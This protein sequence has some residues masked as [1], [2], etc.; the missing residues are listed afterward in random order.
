ME[1]SIKE[2]LDCYGKFHG[3]R[4][5]NFACDYKIGDFGRYRSYVALVYFNN[6][7]RPFVY[8]S[9]TREIITNGELV[10]VSTLHELNTLLDKLSLYF[11][12]LR[13]ETVIDLKIGCQVP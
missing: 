13:H 1:G 11:Q 6:S 12:S 7:V 3:E 4:G 8:D 2:I 5:K 10:E 9:L